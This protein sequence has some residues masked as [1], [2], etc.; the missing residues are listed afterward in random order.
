MAEDEFEWD[1]PKRRANLAKHGV[2]FDDI[3]EAFRHPRIED[4]DHRH[5]GTE[6]RWK[7]L[8]YVKGRVVFFVYSE[9]RGTKRIITA[10]PATRQETMLYF[11]RFWFD[12]WS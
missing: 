1:E 12:V 2:D 7:V 11:R 3:P 9:R 4:Y 5:S 6:D 10:R 8:G